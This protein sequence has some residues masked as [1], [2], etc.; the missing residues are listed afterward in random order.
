MAPETVKSF[1]VDAEV[2]LSEV[3]KSTKIEL[4]FRNEVRAFASLSKK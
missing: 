3:E 1:I 4:D 2:A